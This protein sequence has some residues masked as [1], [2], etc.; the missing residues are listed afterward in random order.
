MS[1]QFSRI[2]IH[3][4]ANEQDVFHWNFIKQTTQNK[5]TL[6]ALIHIDIPNVNKN[7]WKMKGHFK[8]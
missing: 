2:P 8:L 6:V 3:K 5:I 1:Q 4:L 7:R